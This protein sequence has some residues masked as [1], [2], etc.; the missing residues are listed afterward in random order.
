MKREGKQYG[1]NIKKK[2]V[3]SDEFTFKFGINKYDKSN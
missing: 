2:F 3:Y 1:K